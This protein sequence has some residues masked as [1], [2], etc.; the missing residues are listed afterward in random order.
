MTPNQA[1]A[2]VADLSRRNGDRIKTAEA[3]QVWA[4]WLSER[5]VDRDEAHTFIADGED[6]RLALVSTD[7]VR[8]VG[9][10][11]GDIEIETE[12]LGPLC[13]GRYRER[14]EWQDDSRFVLG[15][16]FEHE[17]LLGPLTW[18]YKTLSQIDT[19]NVGE[20]RELLRTWAEATTREQ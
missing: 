4:E 13:G 15:L 5:I 8:I 18:E 7:G 11:K 17:R 9:F 19:A 12:Y 20:L 2:L 16:T 1:E 3:Q 10:G 14:W 6:V